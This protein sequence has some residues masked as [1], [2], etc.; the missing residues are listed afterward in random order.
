MT[1]HHHPHHLAKPAI[2]LLSPSLMNKAASISFDFIFQQFHAANLGRLVSFCW[3][4]KRT[5]WWVNLIV[6]NAARRRFLYIIYIGETNW[7]AV[8]HVDRAMQP[9]SLF[10]V[11]LKWDQREKWI[12]SDQLR[13][14]RSGQVRSG[15]V[16]SELQSVEHYLR[17]PLGMLMSWNEVNQ[18]N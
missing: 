3:Y 11:F 15:Q 13:S 7:P 17:L 5:R 2:L 6:W 14:V 1:T 18:C 16:R 12:R 10:L 8:L 9:P 4:R